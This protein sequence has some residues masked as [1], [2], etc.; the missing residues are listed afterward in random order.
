MSGSRSSRRNGAGGP[1]A[2]PDSSAGVDRGQT[3]PLAA[4]AAL[5]AVGVGLA[6]FAGAAAD[7]PAASDRS[8][9]DPALERATATALDDGV[10]DP[11]DLPAPRTVAPDGY[12]ARVTLLFDGRQRA[13]G[14]RPPDDADRASRPVTVRVAPGDLRS[15][16]LV[17]EV[18]AP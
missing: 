13:V 5:L 4:L 7:G 11:K 14:P 17:V 12:E 2:T 10:V 3:E 6:L 15:G 9:A 18:W 1:A 16:R 8:L